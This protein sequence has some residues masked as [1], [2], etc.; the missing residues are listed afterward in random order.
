MNK[1]KR[2]LSLLLALCM[3]LSILPL[4]AL[5]LDGGTS[6]GQPFPD[7]SK[8][9]YRIPAFVTLDDGTLVAAAD[10]RWKEWKTPDDAGDIDTIVSRSTDNGASWTYSY[11]NYIDNGES[12]DYNYP[13]ATF[14][15]PALATDG[16][17][18]YMIVDLFPGRSSSS[19]NNNSVAAMAGTGYDASGNLMLSTNAS[20]SST[21]DFTHYLKDGKIY[22]YSTNTDQGYAVDAYF[23]VTKDGTDCGNLFN[24]ENS[25]NF[26]P[27]MTSY[28]Y[29]TTST[30]GGATWSEPQMLNPQVKNS[31]EKIFL[32]SPGRGLVTSDGTI[33]FGAYTWNNLCLIYS[34]DR[35]VTWN[36]VTS[37]V[38]NSNGSEDEIVELADGTL[39]MFVRHSSGSQIRYVDITQN[40]DKTYSF[41]KTVDVS[42]T[43]VYGNC[44]ITAI[45]YSKEYD[46]KQVVLVAC[47]GS[48][49]GRYNGKIFT[50]LVDE[51]NNMTLQNTYEVTGANDP[52]SYSCLTEQGDGSIGLLYEKGDSG[53]ITYANYDIA[54]VTNLT[55]A[56]DS[57]GGSDGSDD[58]NEANG[59]ETDPSEPSVPDGS[60]DATVTEE[61]ISN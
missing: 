15:D 40:S 45:S 5:A 58:N 53:N 38:S 9:H 4:G 2:T 59:G 23:H 42:G 37:S 61:K 14:I 3:M 10:V 52:Y 34:N 60:G 8:K 55:F 28:L 33:V 19:N 11:A 41:G 51:S 24:Y 39:R 46:G 1:L 56:S 31:S 43:T 12:G 49:R 18:L 57:G 26:H 6:A 30:D 44:N 35:G 48:T 21:S 32:N 36:R 29:L 17:T 25:C 13:A 22:D 20:A 7:G 27:L 50:F 47:P 54:T 16:N